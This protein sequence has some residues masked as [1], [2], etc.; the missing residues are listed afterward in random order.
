MALTFVVGSLVAGQS[1]FWL[2]V[3]II[4]TRSMLGAVA[5]PLRTAL[6]A[7]LVPPSV[8]HRAVAA[9]AT[10][11]N[12]SRTVGLV[13]AAALLAVV[14]LEMV[15]WVNAASYI[16]VLA[17]LVVVRPWN[18]EPRPALPSQ[19]KSSI[20]EAVNYLR[21]NPSAT[22]LLVLAVAPMVFG[23]PYQTLMP[24]FAR[25]LLGVKE[26]GYGILLSL[27]AAGALLASSWLIFGRAVHWAGR[28]LVLSL[29]AFGLGLVLFT[30]AGNFIVA[31]VL[32]FLVGL[33]SQLYRTMSRITMQVQTPDHLRGRILSIALMDRG[34]IPLGTL[35]LG[36][37][38]E[39]AGTMAA[40][41]VMG[42]GC[43]AVTLLVL[44]F[45]PQLWRLE[46]GSSPR[47]A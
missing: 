32:A 45:R 7:N 37:V 41:L 6:L 12:I 28:W 22:S 30:L 36:A 44:L 21:C 31:A 16:V 34:F 4:T 19:S 9:Q 43:I 42:G 47:R 13:V 15:F 20:G 33:S 14:P 10:V 11:M 18:T 3:V 27:A 17:S 1:P 5:L 2:F 25:D 46:L 35:L 8:L 38:A 39:W 29:M 24:V 40:G 26:T 23:F